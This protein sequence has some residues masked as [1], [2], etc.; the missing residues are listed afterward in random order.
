[1]RQP[2]LNWFGAINELCLHIDCDDCIRTILTVAAD[3][4]MISTG[5]ANHIAKINHVTLATLDDEAKCP[6]NS[7]W[8]CEG[9]VGPWCGYCRAEHSRENT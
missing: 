1:M 8:N 3:E 9:K 5:Q 4:D 2:A 7:D 6:F